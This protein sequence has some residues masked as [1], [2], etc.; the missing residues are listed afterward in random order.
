MMKRINEMIENKYGKWNNVRFIFLLWGLCLV[1]VWTY[2][3]IS[4][5]ALP[6]INEGVRWLTGIL[7]A[8]RVGYKWVEDK[9]PVDNKI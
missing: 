9:I 3:A 7:M 2:I 4:T 8:G 5:E 1:G 6:E